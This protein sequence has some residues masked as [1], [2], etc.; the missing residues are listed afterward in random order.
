MSVGV[1]R[2]PEV[3]V[4]LRVVG[5]PRSA[6]R[7]ER[8]LRGQAKTP[9]AAL[10]DDPGRLGEHIMACNDLGNVRE[11]AALA[12]RGNSLAETLW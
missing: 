9:D 12:R 6:E 3:V 5:G 1:E 8:R 7:P 2:E 11:D 10:L 4:P